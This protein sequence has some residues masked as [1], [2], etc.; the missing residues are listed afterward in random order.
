MARRVRGGAGAGLSLLHLVC[1]LFILPHALPFTLS[2][3]SLTAPSTL[4]ISRLNGFHGR[5]NLPA[6]SRARICSNICSAAR[7]SPAQS[8]GK[9]GELLVGKPT[10]VEELKRNEVTFRNLDY[11][12]LSTGGNGK[13]QAV[14]ALCTR[15]MF[16]SEVGALWVYQNFAAKYAP[17]AGR[18]SVIIVAETPDQ[19]VVGCVGMELMLL[20][21]RGMSW[22]NDPSSVTKLRPYV[23]DL[24]VDSDYQ[25]MGLGQQLLQRC[26]TFVQTEWAD[27]VDAMKPLERLD[28]A[29]DKVFLKVSL[30]NTKAMN[31][32]KK[33]GYR[34]CARAP[35]ELLI[36]THDHYIEWPVLN[37]Y[38]CKQL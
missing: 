5:N 6:R 22:W 32:Y 16:G 27:E 31:L 19:T 29:L 30:D 37:L 14:A 7:W 33:M 17:D 18:K 38:L 1:F 11:L 25:R 13:L 35:E 10:E 3:P 36:P 4:S 28:Y 24:V 21:E 2:P 9:L 34:E 15:G 20:S 26:E 8:L 23:S 12:D